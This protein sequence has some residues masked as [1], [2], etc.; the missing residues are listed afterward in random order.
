MRKR[1]ACFFQ[2]FSFHTS[3]KVF[4][5]IYKATGGFKNYF[6]YRMTVL[7]YQHNL[8]LFGNGQCSGGS[9]QFHYI[10]GIDDSPILSL[11]TIL[12][13]GKINMIA[14]VLGRKRFPLHENLLNVK[15]V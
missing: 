14:D 15:N 9:G 10:I 1:I 3:N 6:V 12:A 8:T 2:Q 7:L 13:G 4:A 5:F 11:A